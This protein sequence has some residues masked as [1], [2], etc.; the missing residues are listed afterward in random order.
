MN[1]FSKIS[2]GYI[3]IFKKILYIAVFSAILIGVSFILTYPVYWFSMNN[4]SL[5]TSIILLLFIVYILFIIGK[6]AFG[7]IQK[8]GSIKNF[9]VLVWGNIINIS[10]W[11]L[12][13]AL[14]Y[15]SYFL[16]Q[17]K[18][19]IAGII[20]LFVSVIYSGLLLYDKYK[21]NHI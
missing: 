12:L 7:K 18:I 20:F 13:F 16:L 9:L 11:I 10:K 14:I 6:F 3:F 15:V 17:Q 4:K 21:K 1:L 19:I 2:K 5:F 8:T